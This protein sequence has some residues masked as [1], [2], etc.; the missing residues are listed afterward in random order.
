MCRQK[1]NGVKKKFPSTKLFLENWRKKFRWCTRKTKRRKLAEETNHK[2][3]KKLLIDLIKKVVS[4]RQAWNVGFLSPL[5]RRMIP[6][7]VF[8]DLKPKLDYEVIFKNKCRANDIMH[9][10]VHINEKSG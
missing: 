3:Q 10:S 8:I 4:R 7:I 1:L 2:V 5:I 9:T 6:E